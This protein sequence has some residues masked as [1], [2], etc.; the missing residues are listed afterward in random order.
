MSKEPKLR[1]LGVLGG[2]NYFEAIALAEARVARAP[3]DEY[4]LTQRKF[5]GD[6][7]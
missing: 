6:G 2:K 3:F 7:E 5:K 1:V 4:S